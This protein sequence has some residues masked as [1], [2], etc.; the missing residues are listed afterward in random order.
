MFGNDRIL[1]VN[2]IK[3]SISSNDF[4]DSIY[5]FFISNKILKCRNCKSSHFNKIIINKSSS[6]CNYS[7]LH[8]QFEMNCRVDSIQLCKNVHLDCDDEHLLHCDVCKGIYLRKTGPYDSRTDMNGKIISKK[9]TFYCEDKVCERNKIKK[10]VYINEPNNNNNYKV[11]EFIRKGIKF[12]NTIFSFLGG[13]LMDSKNKTLN[14]FENYNSY[15]D[16]DDNDRKG[17]FSAWFICLEAQEEYQNIHES[18]MSSLGC[19]HVY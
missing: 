12:G 17:L 3:K 13:K 4:D 11:E 16:N 14:N 9:Y 10:Y 15:D 2:V 8:C 18:V 5:K 6:H 1:Y 19:C 7:C